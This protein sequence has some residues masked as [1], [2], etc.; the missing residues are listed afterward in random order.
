M[1]AGS[2]LSIAGA[3]ASSAAAVQVDIVAMRFLMPGSDVCLAAVGTRYRVGEC[4]YEGGPSSPI[5]V[6]A[7]TCT[8]M[9]M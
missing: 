7:R 3:S 9:S 1:P 6:S 8:L 2:W 5:D 4:H